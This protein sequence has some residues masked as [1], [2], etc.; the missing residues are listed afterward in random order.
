M[1]NTVLKTLEALKANR[2]EAYY[3][4]NKQE[5]LDTVLSLIEKDS[6]VASGGS[7]T[8]KE[9]GLID[10][11]KNQGY[12]YWDRADIKDPADYPA[13]FRKS[14]TAD[15]YLSSSNAI[16]ENGEL[17][18][19][20]GNSNRVA[21]MLYG[22]KSVI[23]VAGINKIVKN[24]EEARQFA[25]KSF[26]RI[27]KMTN[28]YRET[29]LDEG[30]PAVDELLDNVQR[31][32]MKKSILMELAEDVYDEFFKSASKAVNFSLEELFKEHKIRKEL[33]K[34]D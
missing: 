16:T 9:I 28:E 30:N 7:M 20:D 3:A 23:V 1:E 12:D 32:I 13:F 27:S 10:A 22:P 2:M 19:V 17:Y 4:E 34:H 18:N 15:V 29:H 33:A 26:D 31:K 6:S 11:L 21:A 25:E 8:L 14:L 5:A 24:L